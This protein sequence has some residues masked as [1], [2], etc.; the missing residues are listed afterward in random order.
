MFINKTRVVDFTI[1]LGVM[2]SNAGFVEHMSLASTRCQNSVFMN[3]QINFSHISQQ[4]D[5]EG[6]NKPGKLSCST[7]KS[8]DFIFVV[9]TLG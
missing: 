6:G 1:P 8:S 5:L 9:N 3:T 4:H 2:G 7:V